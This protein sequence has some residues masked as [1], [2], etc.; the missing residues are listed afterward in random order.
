MHEPTAVKLMALDD[1]LARLERKR[2][3]WRVGTGA[4]RAVFVLTGTEAAPRVLAEIRTP[5]P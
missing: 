5:W 3:V 4:V 1:W 2:P